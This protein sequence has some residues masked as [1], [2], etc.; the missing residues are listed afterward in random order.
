MPH[1]GP[2]LAV[3]E[4][5][6]VD[7]FESPEH[8]DI[9]DIPTREKL[10]D[11]ARHNFMTDMRMGYHRPSSPV[12][13][14]YLILVQFRHLDCPGPG[15]I[16]C[17]PCQAVD[18][19]PFIQHGDPSH[20][21]VRRLIDEAFGAPALAV[22]TQHHGRRG[23]IKTAD[24]T[25][26]ANFTRAVLEG[27][28]VHWAGPGGHAQGVSSNL[29]NMGRATDVKNQLEIVRRRGNHDWIKI[30]YKVEA[31][32]PRGPL[33]HYSNGDKEE[34]E[35]YRDDGRS[36]D[37]MLSPSSGAAGSDGNGGDGGSSG[38]TQ[39]DSPP[40]PPSSSPRGY[41]EHM[42]THEYDDDNGGG[43]GG[44]NLDLEPREPNLSNSSS[45]MPNGDSQLR[46]SE[47]IDV[48]HLT[49]DSQGQI[50]S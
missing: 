44:E 2:G 37:T 14:P 46:E 34:E 15:P 50:W 22:Y 11:D 7:G 4:G 13:D 1:D 19:R 26:W 36:G 16:R 39:M 41:G 35:E 10:R 48:N 9:D 24:G 6:D 38:D 8:I 32:D 21:P 20:A 30:E 17:D 23:E 49:P 42:H 5:P 29:L 43:N 3:D 31:E 12:S 18:F 25:R 45:F 27:V 40:H 47:S 33:A 28:H